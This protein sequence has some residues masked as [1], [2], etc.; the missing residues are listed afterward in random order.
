MEFERDAKVW[1]AAA[2]DNIRPVLRHVLVRRV[3]E[4]GNGELVAADGYLLAVVPCRL[5]ED[6][7][8]G[9]VLAELFEKAIKAMPKVIS[10]RGTEALM[11]LEVDTVRLLDGSVHRR[12]DESIGALPAYPDF[13]RVIPTRAPVE[14]RDARAFALDPKQLTRMHRALGGQPMALTLS[15]PGTHG[16]RGARLLETVAPSAGGAPTPPFGVIMPLALRLPD[17]LDAAAAAAPAPADM[18]KSIPVGDDEGG[19]LCAACVDAHAT[20]EDGY[21]DGCRGEALA[22]GAAVQSTP[23]VAGSGPQETAEMPPGEELAVALGHPPTAAPDPDAP[24]CEGCGSPEPS[25]CGC[26]PKLACA[27][28]RGMEA[29]SYCSMEHFEAAEA[30]DAAETGGEGDDAVA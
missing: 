23:G 30:L 1:L 29:G 3:D 4:K 5:E 24:P 22:I 21:C 10:R 9:M 14:T 7:P 13:A 20:S 8:D 26:H 19:R 17:D 11:R 27:E 2:Q 12:R 15:P 28:C 18:P 16:E 6:E 25:E